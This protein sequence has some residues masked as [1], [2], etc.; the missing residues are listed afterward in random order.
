MEKEWEV[1]WQEEVEVERKQGLEK[2]L[3]LE[4]EKALVLE[5]EKG[6]KCAKLHKSNKTPTGKYEGKKRQ[7]NNKSINQLLKQQTI[8]LPG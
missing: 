1:E 2:V 7:T 5:Q 4:L 6:W 3:A 8:K